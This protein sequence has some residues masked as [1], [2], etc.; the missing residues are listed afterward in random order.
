MTKKQFTVITVLSVA[1]VVLSLLISRRLW[2]RLDLTRNRAYTLTEVSKNLYKEI[3]DQV[4][5]TY[6]LSEKLSAMTPIPTEIEDLLREYAAYSHGKIRVMVKDPAKLQ[7]TSLVEQLGIQP[8]QIQNIEED[9]ASIATVYSGVAV[10]YLDQTEILPVV[11]SL[12]TLEYDITSRIRSMIRGVS[13]ELGVIVGDESR[14]WMQDY[15]YLDQTLRQAG[16]T[17]REINPGDEIPDAL[18]ALFVFGGVESMDDWALYRIDRYI[19]MGGNALFATESVAVDTQ[20]A[21]AARPMEDKGLLKMLS[22]YGVTVSPS[23]VLDR[24]ALTIQYQ[25]TTRSGARQYHI[26]RYPLWFGV[27][28]DNGASEQPITTRFNGIDLFWASPLEL[29]PPGSVTAEPLFT[30]TPSAWLQTKNFSASPEFG[31]RFDAEPD[32]VGRKTL[33][34]SLHGAFPSYF[35]GQPKPIREGSEETLPDTPTTPKE[36]RVI[37]IGDSD[38]ASAFVQRRENLDFMVQIGL[39]LSNDSDVV[40]IRNRRPQAGRL[41]KILDPVKKAATMNTVRIVNMGLIPVLVVGCGLLLSWRR[42]KANLEV[43]GVKHDV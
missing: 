38:V 8:Q 4:L 40:G 25:T 39:Y 19:Q 22:A 2:F 41:D 24:S 32:T 30:S 34:A 14:Q 37:V 3:P 20:G 42:K 12:D 5:I 33:A 35:T 1:T 9:E 31:D 36:A 6:Y 18:D 29:N 27:L 43:G 28:A 21:L 26:N 11:F 17:V 7:I 23:L 13:V 15:Q 16:F 10:E